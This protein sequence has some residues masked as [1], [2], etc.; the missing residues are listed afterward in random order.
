[1]TVVA[2]PCHACYFSLVTE[3]G[4]LE[5]IA[6]S[7]ATGTSISFLVVLDWNEDLVTRLEYQLQSV[8]W[9]V[10]MKLLYLLVGIMVRLAQ[11]S[12]WVTW[13]FVDLWVPGTRWIL[14][15]WVE[16][17]KHYSYLRTYRARHAG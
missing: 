7:L 2:S 15:A 6:S 1:M 16:E 9:L 14:D 4:A 3:F 12:M 13:P 5:L 8:P 17:L 10:Q 11:L